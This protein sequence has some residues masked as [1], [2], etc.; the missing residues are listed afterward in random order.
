[1]FGVCSEL[2]SILGN[3]LSTNHLTFYTTKPQSFKISVSYSQTYNQLNFS[4]RGL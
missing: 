3:L 1:M 2:A 4:R